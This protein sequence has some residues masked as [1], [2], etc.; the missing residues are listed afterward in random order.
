MIPVL[1][2]TMLDLAQARRALR[3]PMVLVPTMGALHEG[4]RTLLR[5]ARRLAE[6]AGSVIVSVFV[7]PLQ[8]GPGEDFELYPRTLEAD[9]ALCREEGVAVVF[10]PGVAEMYPSLEAHR[11]P[12]RE[13][14]ITV[15]AGPMGD[16]LEGASRPGF[17]CGVLTVIL[18][19]FQVIQPQIAVFGEKDAQQLALVER[20]TKDFNLGI[21]IVAVPTVRDADGLAT[22]SRNTYLSGAERATALAISRALQAAL[23][24]RPRTIDVV[25][26]AARR[27]LDD[28]GQLITPLTVD[29]LV[30][31][32]PVTFAPVSPGFSGNALL[33]VAAKVGTIRLIDNIF[34][35]VT[36]DVDAREPR[37]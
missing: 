11:R 5:R 7:N 24:A 6:P 26:A 27:V 31:A 2:R 35:V 10:A 9:V 37:A 12:G 36:N 18:K 3:A 29:Y 14:L 20:M 16:I 13:Q 17:F 34:L 22:S 23:A 25:L 19:L 30:L 32:D 33:L 8:F 1:A 15:D 28:A 21:Q 4:H